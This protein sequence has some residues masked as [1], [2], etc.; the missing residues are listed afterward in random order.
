MASDGL[1]AFFLTTSDGFRWL[2]GRNLQWLNEKFSCHV[3]DLASEVPSEELSLVVTIPSS[4]PLKVDDIR[5]PYSD[6]FSD[7]PRQPLMGPSRRKFP[8]LL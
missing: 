5:G 6:G 3:V 4:K 7:G 1:L 2:S 8:F